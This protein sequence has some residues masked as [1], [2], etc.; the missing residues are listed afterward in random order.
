MEVGAPSPA[1]LPE[2]GLDHV[3]VGDDNESSSEGGKLKRAYD[4]AL[5]AR[6]SPLVAR[7]KISLFL[8]TATL[9]KRDTWGGEA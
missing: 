3:D 2:D 9:R 8:L 7:V 5:A 4:D 6:G 1:P